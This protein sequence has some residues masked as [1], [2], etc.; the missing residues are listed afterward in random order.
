MLA[1]TF[2]ISFRLKKQINYESGPQ[3][4]YLRITVSKKRV[5]ISTQRECDPSKWN[6]SV[7]RARGTKEDSK[8][9]NAFLDSMQQKVYEAHRSLMDNSETITAEKIKNKLL[10]IA[11]RPKMI[12]EIFQQHNEQIEKLVGHEYAPLTLKRYKTALRHVREFI[13]WK[14][15]VSDLEVGNLEFDF[16]SSYEFYLKSVR[17]CG[18]NSTMKYLSN[19]KKVVLEC[20]KRGWLQR[21]PFFGFKMATR[22]ISR[23]FLSQEELDRIIS[24]EFSVERIKIVKDIFLFSCYTGLAYVDVHKLKRSEITLGIDGEKWIFIKRQKTETS[25]HIPL[26]PI[27]VEILSRYKEHVQYPTL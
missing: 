14:Y 9:L 3:S 6:P 5:E 26:L 7:G 20:V 13:K 23:E 25:A 18:H 19:F 12:L 16:I 21:D 22:E 11:E 17:K 2:S 24:K 4:I 10:G 1:K 8:T 27:C 15:R